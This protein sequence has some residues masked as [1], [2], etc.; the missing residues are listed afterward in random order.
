MACLE[1]KEGKTGLFLKVNMICWGFF[2]F[3]FFFFILWAFIRT[4]LCIKK[5]NLGDSK[6]IQ[7][8]KINIAV[9]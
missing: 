3:L 4:N 9:E 5:L 8:N 7:A 2:V 1:T 6:I